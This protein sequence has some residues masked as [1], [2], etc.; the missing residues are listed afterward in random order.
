MKNIYQVKHLGQVFTPEEI[1]KTML[2]LRRNKGSVLE[3]SCGDGS[4]LKK[5]ENTAVGIEIDKNII[6]DP[7]VLYTDFFNYSLKNK[8]HSIIGNPPYVRFQDI[9]DNTKKRLDMSLFDQRTN[10]YLFFIKK[11]IEHLLPKGELILITPRDFIK[12]TSAIKLNELLYKEGSMSHF[13]DLGDQNIFKRFSPN[14]AIWRW[15]KDIKQKELANAKKFIFKNGQLLF[16]TQKETESISDYFDV[17]VGAVSGADNIFINA[18]GNKNFVCSTTAKDKEL[19]TM[20]YNKK[21]RSLNKY[22]QTLL[23]RRI[24]KFDESNWW[25]WGRKYH[26][27]EGERIYVNCKTRNSKPFFQSDITAYDGSVLALFPR[28]KINLSRAVEKLNKTNWN[29]KGF[30][31]GGRL[32]FSQRSLQNIPIEFSL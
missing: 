10:L 13:Y 6:K 11:C 31:C 12:S 15:V 32:I 7:R 3:P 8:F 26:E 5:L 18:K 21:D 27:K 2:S 20:I 29:K 9:E 24:R 30:V 1:V 23:Q 17:K 22:K 25:E 4:F 28:K 14:C 16:D 19:R